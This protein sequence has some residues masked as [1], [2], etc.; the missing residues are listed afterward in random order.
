MTRSTATVYIATWADHTV[1]T[2]GLMME[3]ALL[4]FHLLSIFPPTCSTDLNGTLSG[5]FHGVAAN[6]EKPGILGEFSEPGKLVKF[7]GNFVQPP[8]KIIANKI[9]LV[10][11][12]VCIKQLFTG[13]GKQDHYDLTE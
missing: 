2:T 5:E 7:S 6:L 11:S 8:G 13:Y 3:G 10:W 12:N 9:I 1:S 4:P